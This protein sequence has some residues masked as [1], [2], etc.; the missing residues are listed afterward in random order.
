MFEQITLPYSVD[1]LEPNIDALTIE[2][3]YGK[4]HKTYTATFNA[5]VEEAGLTGKTAEEILSNLDSISDPALRTAI[6]NNGGGYYNHNL[7][8]ELFSATPAAA[9]TGELAAKIDATFGS[10]D[11]LKEKLTAAA[12]GRFGSGW[13]WLVAKPD[14]SLEVVSTANQDNPYSEHMG[15]P[16]IALDVWEHAY[17]L[18]YKNLRGDYINA[19]FNVLDW[20]KVSAK[21]D[22]I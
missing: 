7:Y 18:K 10:L 1:A 13:A 11:A 2:T 8:F 20:A 12:T 15:T 4:H 3:H 19:F 9:P 14:K 22:A 5:K 16:L 17:Y 6:K 21:Y